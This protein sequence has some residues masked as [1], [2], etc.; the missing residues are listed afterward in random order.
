MTALFPRAPVRLVA[1]SVSQRVAPVVASSARGAVLATFTR[2]AYVELGGRIAVLADEHLLNGPLTILLSSQEPGDIQDPGALRGPPPQEPGT[3]RATG[4]PSVADTAPAAGAPSAATSLRATGTSPAGG[5]PQGGSASQA[6]GTPLTA[7][8]SQAGGIF[9]SIEPGVA[10][11]IR[12][13]ILELGGHWEIDLRRAR[14]WDPR[15]VPI[16]DVVR[17]PGGVEQVTKALAGITAI[18]DAEAPQ[19][20][21]ARPGVRPPRAEHA[22]AQL[23]GALRA[24]DADRAA[25]L[26]RQAAEALAGLGAG[27]T[28]SGDD[29]LAGAMIALALLAPA[30][31]PLLAGEI[32]AAARG[33]TTRISQAYLETAGAGDA[34]EA[35]HGLAAVLRAPQHA[36]V[37]DLGDAVRQ[38][39]AFGETSGSDMLAGFVLGMRELLGRQ[40]RTQ[41]TAPG[42]R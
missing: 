21:L 24:E 27:L 19:G 30:R 36:G 25:A 13:G 20:G 35:W 7:G 18:L 37:A 10:A 42:D 32:V 14:V 38:I 5:A 2:S 15:L 4:I 40:P 9:D 11:L 23:A 3:S 22:M 33:R 29:V 39:M 12:N 1:G 16:A 28:P 41:M 8:T 34:G 17:D 31:A 26:A 6:T